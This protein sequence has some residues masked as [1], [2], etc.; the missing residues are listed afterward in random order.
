MRRGSEIQ[1]WRTQRAGGKTT[2]VMQGHDWLGV[3]I[4]SPSFAEIGAEAVKRWKEHT[5][6]PAL[7]I[8]VDAEPAFATKLH[9]DELCPARQIVF[10]DADWWALRTLPLQQLEKTKWNA[11]LDP[12]V[13]SPRGFPYLDSATFQIP[14]GSYINTG[15]FACDLGEPAH[16]LV[17]ERARC[18]LN[19]T[20]QGAM[21]RPVD[22]TDQVFLNLALQESDKVHL[23]RLP[24]AWNCYK[25]AVDWGTY[26]HMP[27]EIL[28][29]H[30]AGYK[31]AQKL[32]K[33]EDE[34]RVFGTPHCPLHPG[35]K[36]FYQ[37]SSNL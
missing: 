9:L 8:H 31:V 2:P 14:R 12:G 18:L 24:F 13:F 22:W 6:C 4:I 1:N 15:F 19:D 30:A 23:H 32:E 21:E 10:F 35:V 16:R 26:P 29:L 3:T 5:G 36:E 27:R 37:D 17:F 33:L 7:V 34:A 25:L 20:H 28:G 11:V